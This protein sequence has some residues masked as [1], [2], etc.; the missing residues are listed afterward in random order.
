[1][2]RRN[3]AIFRLV[4]F[5]LLIVLYSVPCYAQWQKLSGLDGGDVGQLLSVNGDLYAVI[6]Q[7]GGMYRSTDDGATWLNITPDLPLINAYHQGE[8]YY[9]GSSLVTTITGE[10]YV[11][12]D[13]AA[14]WQQTDLSSSVIFGS[15]RSF[16]EHNGNLYAGTNG[17]GVLIS[18]DGA[19]TWTQMRVGLPSIANVYQ[20]LSDGPTIIAGVGGGTNGLFRSDDNGVSWYQLITTGLP[21]YFVPTK[22]LKAGANYV[23]TGG[24]GIFISQD[25]TAWTQAHGWGPVLYQASIATIDRVGTTLYAGTHFGSIFTS[26]DDGETWTH[27]PA[28]GLEIMEIHQIHS[29]NGKLFLANRAGVKVSTDGGANWAA[30]NNGLAAQTVNSLNYHVGYIFAGTFNGVFRS[31][32]L[33]QTWEQSFSGIEPLVNK[34]TEIDGRLYV[35]TISGGLFRGGLFQSDNFGSTWVESAPG[36]SY[37]SGIISSGSRLLVNAGYGGIYISDDNG[38]TWASSNNGLPASVWVYSLIEFQSDLYLSL[39]NGTGNATGSVYKSTDNGGTWVPFSVNLSREIPGFGTLYLQVQRLLKTSTSLIAVAIS[40]AYKLGSDGTSWEKLNGQFSGQMESTYVINDDVWLIGSFGRGLYSTTD[41]GNSWR[42]DADL[43]PGYIRDIIRINDDIYIG[44]INNGIHKRPVADFLPNVDC[45]VAG[46]FEIKDQEVNCSSSSILVPVD[47]IDEVSSGVIGLDFCLQYDASY[48]SPSGN[49]FIKDVAHGG[50]PGYVSYFL[51]TSTPGQV[52]GILY[53]NGSAPFP[54][55]FSGSGSVVDIEFDIVSEAPP[56]TKLVFSLCGVTESTLFSGDFDHCSASD[57]TFSVVND[58]TFIGTVL[59][60]GKRGKAL[61]YDS[62]NPSAFIAT[63][64]SGSDELCGPKGTEI[65]NTDMAGQFVYEVDE[66][67]YINI[68]RD[69]PGVYGDN[70]ICTDMMSWINGTDQNRAMKIAALDPGFVPSVYQILAA[71]VNRDGKIT[72]ADVTLISARSVMSICAFTSDGVNSL[73]DWMF[74]DGQTLAGDPSFTISATYPAADGA[75]FSKNAVPMVPDC[76]PVPIDVSASCNATMNET[77][78]AILLGD[79][80]GNWKSLDGDNARTLEEVVTGSLMLDVKTDG[81][82]AAKT[83]DVYYEFEDKVESVDFSLT[84]PEDVEPSNLSITSPNAD[85]QFNYNI[86]G[87][88]VLVSTYWLSER[89]KNGYLLQL[90]LENHFVDQAEIVDR[91]AWINSEPARFEDGSSILEVEVSA[92]GLRLYPN[93]VAD[94]INIDWMQPGASQGWVSIYDASGRKAGKYRINQGKNVIDMS[95]VK[96][97][98]YFLLLEDGKVNQT[99]RII[100]AN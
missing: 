53:F 30:S 21:E 1:V 71:D 52:N 80:N 72:A 31:S 59:F 12:N 41:Q 79:V 40:D 6:T 63:E 18:T 58:P 82:G 84:L 38:T 34:I 48:L 39:G 75:G 13:Y 61:Q 45:P 92:D 7:D 74:I 9:T 23:T 49:A 33:G 88:Q 22:L 44:R 42:N 54:S 36:G 32:D 17:D 86:R 81:E 28:N 5:L 56:G 16:A 76:L 11:S 65:F 35:A 29:H 69:I 2:V 25:G 98:V 70:T 93:P 62:L 8:L 87:G 43:G 50:N 90:K 15:I 95:G 67:D 73:D 91:K 89:S 85:L 10:S 51:N 66:G 46:N 57:G 20:L 26:S 27:L 24:E 4:A 94:F 97:G 96:K 47:A 99:H 68:R 77:Y 64:V 100:K 19:V 83:I 37:Y 60:W 55:Y 3:Y 14:T 78:H